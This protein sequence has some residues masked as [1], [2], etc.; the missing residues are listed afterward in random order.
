M[1]SKYF[2][3]CLLDSK[4]NKNSTTYVIVTNLFL[5]GSARSLLSILTN[6]ACVEGEFQILILTAHHVGYFEAELFTIQDGGRFG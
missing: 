3:T 2:F 6:C 1:S 4:I 5:E